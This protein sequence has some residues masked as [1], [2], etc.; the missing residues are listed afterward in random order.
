MKNGAS[1]GAR[2]NSGGHAPSGRTKAT[3]C[4]GSPAMRAT[5]QSVFILY[6]GPGIY[7]WGCF[8]RSP[9]S[10]SFLS[11]L[12]FF[13]CLPSFFP[14]SLPFPSPSSGLSEFSYGSGNTASSTAES[15]GRMLVYFESRKR[16]FWWLEMLIYHSG[17]LTQSEHRSK[18]IFL[19]SP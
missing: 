18:C 1:L 6:S 17:C 3:D 15:R 10:L 5:A 19:D 2:Q 7:F 12:P 8:S 11:F 4:S 13:P 14:F 9:P 16:V